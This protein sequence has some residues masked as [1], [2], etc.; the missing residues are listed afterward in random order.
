M[1]VDAIQIFG[2]ILWI[3]GTFIAVIGGLAL[4]M[5]AFDF[6]DAPSGWWGVGTLLG[7]MLSFSLMLAALQ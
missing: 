5:E 1:I 6:A 4:I 3:V 7:A 2:V